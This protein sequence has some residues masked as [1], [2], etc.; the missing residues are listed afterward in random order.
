MT[1]PRESRA[2]VRSRCVHRSKSALPK[3]RLCY[4]MLRIVLLHVAYCATA[5]CAL[6][7]CALRVA[8]LRVALLRVAS[9]EQDVNFL[10]PHPSIGVVCA[11]R[12]QFFS[13]TIVR[14]TNDV[15]MLRRPDHFACWSSAGASRLGAVQSLHQRA[16]SRAG[17]QDIGDTPRGMCQDIGDIELEGISYGW[18]ATR[19][20]A[21]GV[22]LSPTSGSPII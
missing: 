17:V 7:Y 22:V 12:G 11:V 20:R 14:T 18:R 1:Y 9:P 10:Q 6:R 4:C 5:R 8:L 3:Y 13:R 2:N 21:K 19:A 15:P 16:G